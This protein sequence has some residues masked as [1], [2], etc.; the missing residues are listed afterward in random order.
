MM[1]ET[2]V[3][4]ELVEPVRVTVRGEVTQQPHLVERSPKN[5]GA[6]FYTAALRYWDD[7]AEDFGV[8]SASFDLAKRVVDEA[9]P[10]TRFVASVVRDGEYAN[11]RDIR[12]LN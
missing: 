4:R 12:F 9:A 7:E 5:G 2:V 10:A 8:L 6:K 11:L 3:E 1:T